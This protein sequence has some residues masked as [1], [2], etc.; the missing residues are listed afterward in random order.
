VD[1]YILPRDGLSIPGI[2]R[3]YQDNTSIGAVQLNWYN[4]NPS[5]DFISRRHT[6][7]AS[8]GLT[9]IEIYN[10]FTLFPN[11]HTKAIVRVPYVIKFNQIHYAELSN[12]NYSLPP[13]RAVNLN[14]SS[15]IRGPY[16][17]PD[18]NDPLLLVHFR[19][20]SL[21]EHLIK[22]S[23]GRADL[24]PASYQLLPTN[25][26]A[27]FECSVSEWQCLRKG[28]NPIYPPKA[29]F[30]LNSPNVLPISS[31]LTTNCSMGIEKN[32]ELEGKE[33]PLLLDIA[34]TSSSKQRETTTL[35]LPISSADSS[36]LLE[37]RYTANDILM[38]SNIVKNKSNNMLSLFVNYA[39][40]DIIHSI[41]FSNHSSV[42][43]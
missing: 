23:R 30:V 29:H 32:G 6:S 10:N 9:L 1:E 14:G 13:A 5:S 40:L 18:L 8:S 43:N 21:E 15:W 39:L 24:R 27:S 37:D 28:G 19:T 4:V 35:P 20:G 16:L 26:Y 3:K 41:L 7:F 2:L 31:I 12:Y 11:H 22:R 38:K 34:I 42:L 25:C 33:D 17:D 36:L